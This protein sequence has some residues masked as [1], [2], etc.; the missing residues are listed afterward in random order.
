MSLFHTDRLLQTIVMT[1]C[2]QVDIVAISLLSLLPTLCQQEQGSTSWPHP[3]HLPAL[4]TAPHLDC[5][6]TAGPALV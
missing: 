6:S 5:E 3:Q 4:S 1:T 2:F